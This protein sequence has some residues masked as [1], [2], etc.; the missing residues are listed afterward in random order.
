MPRSADPDLELRW[1]R[2]LHQQ[3]RSCLTIHQF[4]QQEG[5]SPASFHAWKRRL[6]L[7]STR[8]DAT[9]PATSA[10]VPI[11]VA[12]ALTPQAQDAAAPITIQLANG[13]RILLP[14]TAGTDLVCQVVKAVVQAA[15]GMEPSAC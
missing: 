3:S 15:G 14:I 11:L 7:H 12:S 5:I 13:G 6:A 9:P 4:C 8:P 10:F 2:R 1:R